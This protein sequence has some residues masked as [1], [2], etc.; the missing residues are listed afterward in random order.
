MAELHNKSLDPWKILGWIM[1]ITVVAVIGYLVFLNA[2]I[3]DLQNWKSS[4]QSVMFTQAQHNLYAVTVANEF[5]SVERSLSDVRAEQLKE[6]KVVSTQLAALSV[7]L[8][9]IELS[10]KRLEANLD[11]TNE[12]IESSNKTTRNN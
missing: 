1:D 8:Q 11:R 12:K 6:S 9:N 10:L 7:Q 3:T 5:R 2:Q 4:T